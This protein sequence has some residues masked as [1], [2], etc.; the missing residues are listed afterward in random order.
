MY[1]VVEPDIV[2]QKLLEQEGFRDDDGAFP[3]GGADGALAGAG[4]GLA[5]N[6]PS[7]AAVPPAGGI[8]ETGGAL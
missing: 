4:V 2:R 8:P 3:V 7:A 6:V 1:G 5:R